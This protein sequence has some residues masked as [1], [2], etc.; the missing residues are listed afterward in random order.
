MVKKWMMKC[1]SKKRGRNKKASEEREVYEHN[2][3]NDLTHLSKALQQCEEQA[4]K[5]T[6]DRHR[7]RQTGCKQ[8]RRRCLKVSK[9]RQNT[10]DMLQRS[11]AIR[12]IVPWISFSECT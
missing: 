11:K 2:S 12:E 8:A 1:E 9:D 7:K 6:R 5:L 3:K 10:R 4:D